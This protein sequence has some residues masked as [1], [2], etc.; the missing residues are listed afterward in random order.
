MVTSHQLPEEI[1]TYCALTFAGCRL[2]RMLQKTMR[3]GTKIEVIVD[4]G[5]ELLSGDFFL[6]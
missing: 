1:Q 3:A 5:N 2:Y 6:W 4:W